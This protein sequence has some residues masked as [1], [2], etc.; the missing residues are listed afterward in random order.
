MELKQS[1]KV[2]YYMAED[3]FNCTLWN[4]NLSNHVR[5]NFI[6]FLLIVPYGIETPL[7][8]LW[9]CAETELLIVPYGI[10][11][12]VAPSGGLPYFLLIVPYG[13]ETSYANL[14]LLYQKGF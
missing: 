11:T 14:E 9:P 3:A 10:E 8:A 1:D 6:V 5:I 7:P 4:W 12:N 13:I 2:I